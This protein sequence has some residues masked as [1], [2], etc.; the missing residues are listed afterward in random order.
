MRIEVIYYEVKRKEFRKIETMMKFL[1]SK[2]RN[3]VIQI[4][5]LRNGV[6]QLKIL[7]EFLHKIEWN[8]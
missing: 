2:Q 7:P 1:K 3:E 8:E 5:E 6:R 4:S